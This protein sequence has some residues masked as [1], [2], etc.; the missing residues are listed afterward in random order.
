MHHHK[1]HHHKIDLPSPLLKALF[2]TTKLFLFILFCA[3]SIHAQ[4]IQPHQINAEMQKA[5][6]FEN[7]NDLANAQRIYKNL[8]AQYPA[9]GDIVTRLE[10]VYTRTGQHALSVALLQQHLKQSPN[11]ITTQLKLGDALFALGKQDEAF[12]AWETLLTNANS[13][14]PFILVANRYL[15]N[16]I[17]DRATVVYRQARI[18]LNMPELFAKDLA[19]LAARQA[20]Y[21]EA[22]REYIIFIRQKPQYRHIIETQFRDMA[23]NGDQ[24]TQILDIL[25]TELHQTPDNRNIL[26]LLI[27]YALPAGFSAKALHIVQNTPNLPANSWTYLS[28]IARYALDENNF[29]TATHAYQSLYDTVNRPDVRARALIGLAHTHQR[30]QNI[31]KA[32]KHYQAVIDQFAARPEADEARFQIG[33]FERDI[34]HNLTQA[35]QTF[36]TLI[37]T[38]RK[39]EWRYRALFELAEG[40][41]QSNAYEK[42]EKTWT[43]ILVERQ[44]GPDAAQA[45]YDMA[46]LHFYTGDFL[47]AKVL[48]NLILTKDL[49]QNV[50]N[51]AIMQLALIEEGEQK[52]SEQLKQY[53][54][55]TLL[56]RQQKLEDAHAAFEQFLKQHPHTFLTDRIFYVQAELLEHQK[57]YTQAIQQYRKLTTTLK[58]SPLCPAAQM[59]MAQIYDD[60]LAQYYD[61]K[62]AYEV[63]LVDYPLSFEADLARE[64][65]RTLQQKIQDIE[66]PKETG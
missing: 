32:R 15:K 20:H 8:Y 16:S 6:A 3:T 55:A 64:R 51:D 37:N 9:R 29:E 41:L 13:P 23:I 5:R 19:E 18:T 54:H 46:Q 17:Y 60:H 11:D 50:A 12:V 33:I 56:Y 45:R 2:M 31:E 53:A 24:Q 47:T 62:R 66:T 40:H 1:T 34:D 27:E 43:Q 36:Q 28:R 4:T 25:I 61:A 26:G 49:G 39:N 57:Q 10:Q 35:Q 65:L 30:A 48:L 7:Q 52:D 38:N 22:V 58:E 21:A 14:N 63:L 44:S 59:A 42:A